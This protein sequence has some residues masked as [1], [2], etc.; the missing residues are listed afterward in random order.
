MAPAS[1]RLIAKKLE[2]K[3]IYSFIR[4]SDMNQIS[5]KVLAFLKF[6]Y[7][8]DKFNQNYLKTVR[9]FKLFDD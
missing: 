4:M 2:N 1:L 5:F 8:T 3:G 7:F 9:N 6:N